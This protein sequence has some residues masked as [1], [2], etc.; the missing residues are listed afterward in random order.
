[1]FEIA[2]KV[3]KK[4]FFARL[5][6]IVRFGKVSR[7]VKSIERRVIIG[8]KSFLVLPD[9]NLRKHAHSEREGG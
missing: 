1:M 2:P 5:Q 3:P 4:W 6:S 7:K 9:R 8:I